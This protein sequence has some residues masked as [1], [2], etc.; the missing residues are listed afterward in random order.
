ML[1]ALGLL[2][3]G[4][5]IVL[6]VHK[7][8]DQ[9]FTKPIKKIETVTKNLVDVNN[10]GKVSLADAKDATK[11][12]AKKAGKAAKITAEKVKKTVGRKKKSE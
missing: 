5:L 9:T 12:V 2:V 7:Q 8:N 4:A 3:I 10:D 1:T 11:Q 6:W